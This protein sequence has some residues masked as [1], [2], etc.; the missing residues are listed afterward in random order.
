MG[1][2]SLALDPDLKKK[3]EKLAV[4][5]ELSINKMVNEIL[6]EYAATHEDDLK[7]YDQLIK[8]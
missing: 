3:I 1:R 8:K 7:R 6:T 2:L 5:N 4:I